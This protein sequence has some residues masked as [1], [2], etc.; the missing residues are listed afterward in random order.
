MKLTNNK[1]GQ[2]FNT[3]SGLAVGVVA[4]AILLTITFLILSEGKD[5]AINNIDTTT[6]TE[7]TKTITVN[8]FYTFS[9]CIRT[10]AVSLTTVWNN[11]TAPNYSIDA[12]NWTIVKNTVN[13]SNDKAYPERYFSSS[14]N[15]TYSCKQPD[16]AYNSTTEMQNATQDIPSWA[17]II[18]IIV[19]GG[20]LLG[21]VQL[22]RRRD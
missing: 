5:Q 7:K 1:K 14:I 11:A 9:E 19:I 3:L 6:F 17:P 18:I 4:L 22:F 12:G 2:A 10:Q 21:L 16:Y 15:L 8:Q 13:F 20:V